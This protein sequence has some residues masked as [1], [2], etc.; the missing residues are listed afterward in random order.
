MSGLFNDIIIK[1]KLSSANVSGTGLEKK[2]IQNGF[3][4][5][6][7]SIVLDFELVVVGIIDRSKEHP[8]RVHVTRYWISVGLWTPVSSGFVP[9]DIIGTPPHLLGRAVFQT[10]R[11][12]RHRPTIH[13][14]T[15]A[16]FQT[17]NILVCPWKHARAP[18]FFVLVALVRKKASSLHRVRDDTNPLII[19]GT[20]SVTGSSNGTLLS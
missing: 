16:H 20:P 12:L 9:W 6:R 15:N 11:H 10:S 3:P 5:S 13:T 19:Q 17:M 2:F 4:Q 8:L 18:F 1:K 7:S 14:L